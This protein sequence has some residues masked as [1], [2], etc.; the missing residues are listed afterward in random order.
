MSLQESEVKFNLPGFPDEQSG[1]S[2]ISQNS[3]TVSPDQ[4]TSCIIL[5]AEPN[6]PGAPIPL[7]KV[8]YVH[9]TFKSLL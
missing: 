4:P 6:T 1:G 5:Q 7:L 3:L 2:R 8:A 9:S